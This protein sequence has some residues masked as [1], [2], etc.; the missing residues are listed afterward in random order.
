MALT[1][2]QALLKLEAQYQAD[3]AKLIESFAK[4][5]DKV[6]KQRE[7]W[8]KA[9]EA[10]MDYGEA[11]DDYVHGL[12]FALKLISPPERKKT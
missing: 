5:L 2:K 7:E 9:L 3:R 12:R 10:E 11:D 1:P 8:I 6:I 4:K